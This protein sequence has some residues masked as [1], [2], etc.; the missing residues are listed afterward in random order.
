MTISTF[1]KNPATRGNGLVRTSTCAKNSELAGGNS[2]IQA[3]GILNY[4]LH[5]LYQGGK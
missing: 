1:A 4:H 3:I 5:K 2:S